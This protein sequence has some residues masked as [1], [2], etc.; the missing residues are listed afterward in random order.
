MRLVAFDFFADGSA[1]VSTWNGDV[2]LVSE[3]DA[4][5]QKV[6]WKRFAAG[7]HEP[8]GL[9][10]V[11]GIV[12][13]LGR[14]GIT[15][16]HDLNNDGEADYY[17]NFNNDVPISPSYHAFA[18]DLDTDRTGNFYHARCGQRIDPAL[19]LNGGIV[20]VSADGSTA[21][22]IATGLRAANGLCVGPNDEIVCSD[23]QGNWIPSS[24]INLIRPG[25]FYGYT[26]HARTAKPPTD[27]EKPICWLPISVD[28]SS[29]SQCWIKNDR[30]GPFAGSLLH[31]S[32]G[33]AA[34]FL[35][36][37]EQVDSQWQGG[38]FQFPLR[39]ES[40]IMRARFHPTD[41]QLYVCGLKGWQTTGARDGA[42]QRVRFTGQPV[43]MP[44]ELHVRPQGIEL[45]FTAT[46]DPASAADTQNWAVQQWNYR[47]TEAYG[48]DDYSVQD[49]ASKGRDPVEFSAIELSPDGRKVLIKIAKLQPV[50]QMRIQFRVKAE[51]GEPIS[52][53]VY[54]TINRIPL[55][56]T[57]R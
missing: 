54:N 48:S 2:W 6:T 17:E 42:F 45:D 10:I 43:R 23:N 28:N 7:L 30:W 57:Q 1:A 39:F 55:N 18:M 33:K 46:L 41:G 37:T 11:N 51:D 53:E 22:L 52:G 12:H 56:L 16:L 32:Y 29:G 20:R 25:R 47:W 19:P 13:V 34:L 5:L 26:P 8:L 9:K 14:D 50:M 31:T 27:Q 21:E 38:V 44:R 35:L 15:R 49:P 24:R 4:T 40:G 36:M 3:I